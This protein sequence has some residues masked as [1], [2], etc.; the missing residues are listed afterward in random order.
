M[1]GPFKFKLYDQNQKLATGYGETPTKAAEE[2]ARRAAELEGARAGQI[3][4]E[5]ARRIRE[6]NTRRGG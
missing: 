5:R 4:E 1:R 2:M 3:A 6:I